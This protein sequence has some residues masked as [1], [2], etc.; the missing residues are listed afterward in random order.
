VLGKAKVISY[1]DLKEARAKRVVKDSAQVAKGKGNR[2]RKSKSSPPKLEEDIAE[3]ARRERKRK[4]AELEAPELTNKVARMSN[5]PKPESALVMQASRTQT[6]DDEI[7][8]EPYRAPMA[9]MY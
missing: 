1:K 4:S 6:A 9:R 7:A 8:P 2:G 5:A 3:T